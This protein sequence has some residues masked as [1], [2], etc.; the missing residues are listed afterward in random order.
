MYGPSDM[1]G[2]L[3]LEDVDEFEGL[4][5]EDGR[6][7]RPEGRFDRGFREEVHNFD[8][9]FEEI[10]DEEDIYRN[11]EDEEYYWGEEEDI[12]NGDGFLPDDEGL[13]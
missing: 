8:E 13:I 6:E 1:Y 9:D 12:D 2:D 10:M 4:E 11:P 3:S 5:P 7:V